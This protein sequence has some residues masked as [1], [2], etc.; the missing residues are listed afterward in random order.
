MVHDRLIEIAVGEFSSKGLEGASTRG[1]AAAAGTAMS[2]ITYHYGGKSGLY[3]AVADRIACRMTEMMG[4]LLGDERVRSARDPATAPAGI[5]R[6]LAR[7]ADMM[8]RDDTADWTLFVVREQMNPT[9]AFDRLYEGV[10]GDM[11]TTLADLVVLATACDARAARVATITL[12]GQVTTLRSSRATCVRLLGHD[13]VEPADIVDIKARIGAN[14]DAILHSM[15]AERRR[16][17]Q[18]QA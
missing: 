16:E 5:R 13:A 12:M 11:V 18:G 8:V 10:M 9:T 4:D 6:I 1:I 17:Q 15:R 2:S 3:L 7:F 14:I